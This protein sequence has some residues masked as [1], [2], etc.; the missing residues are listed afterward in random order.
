MDLVINAVN[1]HESDLT[2]LFPLSCYTHQIDQ[3]D[4][5]S[6]KRCKKYTKQDRQ[7][8]FC[9]VEILPHIIKSIP[10]HHWITDGTNKLII[11]VFQ[12]R[13]HI[14]IEMIGIIHQMVTAE[15]RRKHQR[16]F[17][18]LDF[19]PGSI[20]ADHIALFILYII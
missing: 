7:T 19:R 15:P 3:T 4:N 18:L 16:T 2:A 14:C 5:G 11:A 6:Q 12:D 13:I 17:C 1:C 8:I 20:S 10:R 9:I